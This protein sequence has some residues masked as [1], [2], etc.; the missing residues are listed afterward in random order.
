MPVIHDHDEHSSLEAPESVRWQPRVRDLII[1]LVF[2]MGWLVPLTVT[3]LRADGLRGLPIRVRDFY[4]VS[5]LFDTRSERISMFYAQ[6]RLAGEDYWRDVPED[7]LFQLEPFGHRDRF[8]RFMARFGCGD[9]DQ[10]ARRELAEWLAERYAELYPESPPV[11]AVRYLWADEQLGDY[12]PPEGEWV[13]PE[14]SEMKP[15]WRLG[16]IIVLYSDEDGS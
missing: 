13:K 5:C 6:F 12:P 3:A 2:V 15:L 1:A 8:D 7:E 10:L 9:G 16:D 14:R 4:S 11:V